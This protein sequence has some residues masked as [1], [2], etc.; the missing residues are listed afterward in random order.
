MT[1]TRFQCFI[2][3]ACALIAALFI[4]HEMLSSNRVLL[5][6]ETSQAIRKGR[7]FSTPGMPG[8][9]LRTSGGSLNHSDGCQR[10]WLKG[11]SQWFDEKFDSSLSPLWTSSNKDLPNNILKWWLVSSFVQF[12]CLRP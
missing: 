8:S 10:L 5:S 2:I 1:R 3:G 12:T 4:I 9:D 7:L 6:E 11:R